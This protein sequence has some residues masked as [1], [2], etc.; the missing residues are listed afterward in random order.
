MKRWMVGPGSPKAKV[1]PSQEHVDGSGDGLGR[2]PARRETRALHQRGEVA[3]PMLGSPR[4][5]LDCCGR[6]PPPKPPLGL[7]AQCLVRRP[8]LPTSMASAKRSS[9][10]TR[11]RV[12]IGDVV[13]QHQASGSCGRSYSES[14]V[15]DPEGAGPPARTRARVPRRRCSQNRRRGGAFRA[16]F[17]RRPLDGTALVRRL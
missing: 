17:R 3:A 1:R 6:P 10:R 2:S 9:H 11:R 14:V 4:S 15:P 5:R 12:L 7:Q 16:D 8:S 13:S